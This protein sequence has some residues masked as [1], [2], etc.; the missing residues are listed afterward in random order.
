MVE[1]EFLLRRPGEMLSK[2][3]P[4]SSASALSCRIT[5]GVSS[6]LGIAFARLKTLA[7]RTAGRACVNPVERLR[8]ICSCTAAVLCLRAAASDFFGAMRAK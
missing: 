3:I 6:S 5:F 2:L 7:L 4:D 1:L 8:S